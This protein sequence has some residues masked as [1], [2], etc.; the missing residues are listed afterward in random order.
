[1]V[2]LSSIALRWLV[3]WAK[4]HHGACNSGIPSS[5]FAHAVSLRRLTMGKVAQ[6]RCTGDLA[7]PRLVARR[8]PRRTADRRQRPAIR[9]A[10]R[11][12]PIALH[13]AAV[14]DDIPLKASFCMPFPVF[15]M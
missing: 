9:H 10:A 11:S 8:Q 13:L 5:A 14:A 15:A 1:M 6:G 4:A 2:V 7:H 12:L 3:G